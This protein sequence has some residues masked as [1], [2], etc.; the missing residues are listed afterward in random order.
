MQ[1]LS[2]IDTSLF[3]IYVLVLIAIAL[4]VSRDK[5]GHQKNTTDYFMAGNSLPWWAVGASLSQPI[6]R[7]NKL[8]ACQVLA[9]P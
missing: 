6:S 7:L 3:L 1:T 9:M 8:L 4:W 5:D 2:F